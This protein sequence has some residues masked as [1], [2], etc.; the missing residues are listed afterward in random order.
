MRK[1]RKSSE[2]RCKM[3]SAELE[4]AN[5]L[6]R[7]SLKNLKEVLVETVLRWKSFGYPECDVEVHA[8]DSGQFLPPTYLPMTP[9]DSNNLKAKD[10]RADGRSDASTTMHNRWCRKGGERRK[11]EQAE[12]KLAESQEQCANP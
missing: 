6:H 8:T 10:V 4:N 7:T 2:K 9:R 3:L 1:N 12:N 11:L 5:N